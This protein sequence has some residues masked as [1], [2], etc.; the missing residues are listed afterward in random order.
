ME[1]VNPGRYH[2]LLT[3]IGRPVQHG[4]WQNEETARRKFTRWIGEYGNMPQ[5]RVPLTDEDAGERLASWPEE[6]P[7]VVSGQA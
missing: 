4:W 6:N 3:S 2:L 1:A 5:P 7:G